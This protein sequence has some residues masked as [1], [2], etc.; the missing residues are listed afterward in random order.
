MKKWPRHPVIYEINTWIWLQEM[1]RKYGC[2]MTLDSVPAVEWDAVTWPGIDAV[3]LMGVWERSAAGLGVALKNE[4]LVEEFFKALPDLSFEEVIGSAY[5]VRNYSVDIRLGGPEGLTAARGELRK[6]GVR[7]ILDFVPNHLAID[8]LWV[9]EHPEYFI[10]GDLED[11]AR[12]PV[13]FTEVNGEVFACGRDPFFPAW[14][15]VLQI[16]AFHPKL[17]QALIETARNIARQCDGMRCDMAMLV[18]NSVFRNTW[19]D[20]AGPQPVDEFWTQVIQGVRR[21]HPGV[22]FIAE[23][24]W[25][26][27]WELQQQGFDFC[28]DKRLY[29]RLV[30][31]GP[32]SVRMHLL[33]DLSYQE[34]LLRFIENHDEPRAAA[35]FQQGR[36]RAA[37][38]ASSTLPGARLFHEGQ[39]EGRN[40]RIPVFLTRRPEE[41]ID[42][43]LHHFYRHLI[44]ALRFEALKN[45][46]WE[47]C[48]RSGWPDNPTCSNLVAWCWRKADERLCIVVNLSGTRSQA[49]VRIPWNDIRDR[50]CVL[51]DAFTGETFDRDGNIMLDPGL[52][53]DLDAWAFHF[54]RLVKSR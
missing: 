54:L 40:V 18:L 46:Q 22:L 39:F 52:F 1:G 36:I 24:Y 50:Q 3:W 41:R 53:V 16:N 38:V 11:A 49:L 20:R 21:K 42:P 30:H 8:H 4:R 12:D 9:T 29:D 5:C 13:S 27:E 44:D 47:L 48:D 17:R 34:R 37:A 43:E 14:Q 45:G 23:A 6:R 10:H 35:V 33:A 32:E 15:D 2:Q 19:G 31:D 7:L 25:D 26:L 28:Y 51:E